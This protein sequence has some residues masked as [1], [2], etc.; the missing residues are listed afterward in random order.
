MIL[1]YWETCSSVY[2]GMKSLGHRVDALQNS[3]NLHFQCLVITCS[4]TPTIFPFMNLLIKILFIFL[5]VGLQHGLPFP[6]FC[7][8]INKF[9]NRLSAVDAASVETGIKLAFVIGLTCTLEVGVGVD[10]VD[11]DLSDLSVV[12][13]FP[14][15]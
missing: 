12:F 15:I 6:G 2:T 11:H 14:K 9:N 3:A 4:E 8:A 1:H 10:C 13:P 7:H 5:R